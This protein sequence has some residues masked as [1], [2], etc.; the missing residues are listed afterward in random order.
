MPMGSDSGLPLNAP[1]TVMNQSDKENVLVGAVGCRR[2][3]RKK[4][5]S[6]EVGDSPMT[7]PPLKRR[8]GVGRQLIF[9]EPAADGKILFY[10]NQL[11]LGLFVRSVSSSSGKVAT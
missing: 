8:P 4:D 11:K 7:L 2:Q 3:K 10:C 6:I 5:T 1:P 9:S